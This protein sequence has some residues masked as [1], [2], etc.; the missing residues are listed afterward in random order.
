MASP[1]AHPYMVAKVVVSAP[2]RFRSTTVSQ[3]RS[4]PYG[5]SSRPEGLSKGHHQ[6]PCLSQRTR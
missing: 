2:E 5:L 3:D 4:F 6:D 1:H